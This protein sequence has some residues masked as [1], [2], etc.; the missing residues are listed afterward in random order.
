MKAI[1]LAAILLSS[2]SVLGAVTTRQTSSGV[3][4]VDLS[5]NTGP[6]KFI[7]SGWIYGFPDNGVEA[8]TSIPENFIRD[9]KFVASRAGGAQTP[10]RG[11][12]DGYQGYVPRLNSTISNYR[13][14]RKYDGTFILLVHDLWGA[15]GSNIPLY[16]G[17]GGNWTEAESFFQQLADDL[18]ANDMLEEL[19]IDIWNEPDLTTFWN[20][21]WDQYLAYYARAHNFF[22]RALPS[23]LVSGPS[24]AVSP[25]LDNN[26]W[27]TWLSTIASNETVPDIYSWH[28]IGDWSREPDTTIPDLNTLKAVDNLPDLPIDINEYAW[29]TEQTPGCSVFYIAQ[30]ERHN[31]RGLR[32]NWGSTTALHDYLANLI[33][34]NADG[35]YYPN[36]EWQLYK[37]YASML[38]DRVATTASSDRL[39]DV[40]ATKDGSTV[41]VI[42]GTRTVQAAYN[43][44]I[45][46][47]DSIGLVASGKVDVRTYRFDWA[48]PTGEMGPP[49]DLGVSSFS[50]EDGVINILVDFPTNATAYAYEFSGV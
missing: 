44:S 29:P 35:E 7:A 42:A 38:G 46:G 50:H 45:S 1:S 10:S 37:Y 26:H 30:L 3:A 25:S 21:P 43:F 36:G 23:T 28:Q 18:Q 48:G 14:T 31:L 5:K 40:Y 17:D 16:P 13:T 24:M 20:R 47:L 15:D 39:F 49:T 33:Y 19:V 4:T 12:I 41:K 6:A 34:K 2:I 22:K 9:V 11:W 8:D 32:A 27:K